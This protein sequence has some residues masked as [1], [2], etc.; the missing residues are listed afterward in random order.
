MPN[1][2]NERAVL[3]YY[4]REALEIEQ[5]TPLGGLT[6]AAFRS[7]RERLVQNGELVRSNGRYLPV[8]LAGRC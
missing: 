7:T 4:A 8:A 6:V 5:P 3:S 2:E 1:Q